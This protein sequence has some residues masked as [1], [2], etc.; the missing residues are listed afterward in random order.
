MG[1]R[2]LRE[3]HG[4]WGIHKTDTWEAS[5]GRETVC[6]VWCQAW[7]ARDLLS[8]DGGLGS[9]SGLY[10]AGRRLDLFWQGEVLCL[11]G[12]F[13]FLLLLLF[14]FGVENEPRNMLSTHS[15]V[16]WAL[17]AK[18]SLLLMHDHRKTDWGQL[19]H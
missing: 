10:G 19:C 5:G 8:L 2:R 17:A 13:F 1:V 15:A 9:H 14:T 4:H 11:F 3:S 18:E 6:P 12:F 7:R 16:S